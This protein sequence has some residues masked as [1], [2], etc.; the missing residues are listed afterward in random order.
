MTEAVKAVIDAAFSTYS[1][2]RLPQN[3]IERGAVVDEAWF[4]ILRPE[5]SG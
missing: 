5:W 4:G 3:R 1:D 2:L